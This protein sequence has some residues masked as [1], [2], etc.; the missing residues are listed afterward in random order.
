MPIQSLPKKRYYILIDQLDENWADDATRYR[1]IRALI[2]T[3]SGLN[4]KVRQAKVVIALRTDL[5]EQVLTN[6]TDSGFQG[7][8]YRG[9]V[10]VLTWKR[11]ALEELLDRRV[12]STAADALE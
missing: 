11:K 10:L 3:M 2:E 6:T 8:K 4:R 7:E 1:L 9:H 5:F 12:S